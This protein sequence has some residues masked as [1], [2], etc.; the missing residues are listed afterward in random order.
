MR[1]S[2]GGSNHGGSDNTDQEYC[3]DTA[4]SEGEDGFYDDEVR[5]TEKA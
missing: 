2:T 3:S 4:E 1:D 5:S